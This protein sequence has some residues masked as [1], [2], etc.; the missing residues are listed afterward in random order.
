MTDEPKTE[1]MAVKEIKF[2]D[3]ILQME[4]PGF[5]VLG[6]NSVIV[7]FLTHLDPGE[8]RWATI[9][10]ALTVP[11]AKQLVQEM[12]NLLEGYAPPDDSPTIVQ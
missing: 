12:S 6:S 4:Y 9:K 2:S 10:L 8:N 5:P 11:Q 1:L 7:C 3:K